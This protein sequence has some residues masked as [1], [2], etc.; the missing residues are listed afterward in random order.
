MT[1]RAV[2]KV[3]RIRR[4]CTNLDDPEFSREPKEGCG[5]IYAYRFVKSG[6][7]YI[8]QTRYSVKKRM[9]WHIS[10]NMIV[11]K[12][13]RSG[14]EFTM[15]ILSE[16]RLEYLDDAEDYCIRHFGTLYPDGYNQITGMHGS[17]MSDPEVVKKVT[18]RRRETL[19][20]NPHIAE[21]LG[22]YKRLYWKDN[23]D[24]IPERFRPKRVMCLE[25]GR[26]YASAT[27]AA[28]DTGTIYVQVIEASKLRRNCATAGGY[29][30]ITYLEGY[31]TM[32]EEI[33][34]SYTAYLDD[35]RK[36]KIEKGRRT[37]SRATVIC[38][39]T[40]TRFT[41]AGEASQ[42]LGIALSHLR[43]CIASGKPAKGLHF[44]TA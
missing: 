35:I 25:T 38:T 27:E 5:F 26:I 12:V 39:E 7:M 1:D 15:E 42:R 28:E 40:G 10:K 41:S 37:K 22:E 20:N 2:K 44:V 14:A 34:Q 36:C 33:L 29:H 9:M 17:P 43:R 31:E 4:N 18:E 21:R 32:R 11:D 16:T 23:R 19:K 24:K 8:G 13:I 6:K 3:K 30:W